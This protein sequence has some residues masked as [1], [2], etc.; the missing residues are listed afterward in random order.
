MEA[1]WQV[2]LGP[3]VQ[4]G[5]ET[6]SVLSKR[7]INPE[8]EHTTPRNYQ[9][10]CRHYLPL[11]KRDGRGRSHVTYDLYCAVP[12][13]N[14]LQ[15]PCSGRSKRNSITLNNIT[16]HIILHALLVKSQGYF[17]LS[18]SD[19][20]TVLRLIICNI[21]PSNQLLSR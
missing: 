5:P 12:A 17:T 2:N 10:K 21:P 18:E 20:I 16:R 3:N 4:F 8:F 13:N 1:Q 9:S 11:E 7:P 14:S 15:V 19:N 6:K